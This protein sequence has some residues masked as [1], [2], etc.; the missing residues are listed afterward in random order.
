MHF[1]SRRKNL[2]IIITP[3]DRVTDTKGRP[4]IIRGRTVEFGGGRYETDDEDTI[5]ELLQHPLKGTEFVS[6]DDDVRWI[7]EHPQK[8]ITGARASMNIPEKEKVETPKIDIEAL[9][10][11]RVDAELSRILGSLNVP[12]IDVP[13]TEPDSEDK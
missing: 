3:T 12:V 9:I 11:Q 5:R 13:K 1:V 4:Q 8:V 7:E 10:K 2:R 6:S